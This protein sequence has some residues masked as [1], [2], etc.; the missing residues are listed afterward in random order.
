MKLK[1]HTRMTDTKQTPMRVD[2]PGCY[3]K[4]F[5]WDRTR[6][7]L[8]RNLENRTTCKQ[9]DGEGWVWDYE[10]AADI[11]SGKSQHYND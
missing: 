7:Y 11:A 1:I 10:L 3:R 8:V 4:G 2:C 6:D 5:L 9:C